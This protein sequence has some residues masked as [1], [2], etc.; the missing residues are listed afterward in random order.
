MLTYVL[1]LLIQWY[2]AASDGQPFDSRADYR[3][4]QPY[5]YSIAADGTCTDVR[6]QTVTHAQAYATIQNVHAAIANPATVL[7][8]DGS[9][10]M[11]YHD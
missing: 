3:A 7:Y 2:I 4:T 6:G 1:I 10:E 8:D 5:S 9:C 11:R